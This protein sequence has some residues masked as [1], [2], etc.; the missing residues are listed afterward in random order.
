MLARAEMMVFA[1]LT[2]PSHALSLGANRR[3]VIQGAASAAAMAA[4]PHAALA[5]TKDI[6]KRKKANEAPPKCYGPNF[7]EVPCAG[8]VESGVGADAVVDA[9]KSGG[10]QIDPNNLI[11][12]D[13]SY[14]PG[15]YPTI[16]GKLYKRAQNYEFKSKQDVYDALDTDAERK[17][18]KAFDADIVI[19]AQDR[20]ALSA[21]LSTN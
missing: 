9:S 1:L 12:S 16:G 11:A 7:V 8:T 19:R 14:F 10:K 13:Y 17:V 20:Q 4:V 6:A 15:L 5:G 18:L 21:K 3:A 2:V